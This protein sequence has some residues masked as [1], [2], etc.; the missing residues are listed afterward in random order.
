[1]FKHK[2]ALISVF[3]K[4]NIENIAKFLIKKNFNIYST[5][6]TSKLLKELKIP[7]YEVSKYTGQKEIL[8]GRVKTLHP[9]IHA[10]ILNKRNNKSHH[11]DLIDNNFAI[12]FDDNN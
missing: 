5:G 12:K 9:K 7:F 6:G 1:M 10:G 11:Q 3:D 2:N 4:N 8:G